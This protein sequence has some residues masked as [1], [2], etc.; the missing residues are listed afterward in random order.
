ML[1]LLKD[2]L[3]DLPADELKRTVECVFKC[4]TLTNPLVSTVGLKAIHGLFVSK[5]SA[6]RLNQETNGQLIN[7]NFFRF[8]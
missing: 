7:V 3:A 8:S 6:E 2:I 5:P 4:M 1:G